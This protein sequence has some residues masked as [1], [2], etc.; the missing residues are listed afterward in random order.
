ML[1]RSIELDLNEPW[2]I[3]LFYSPYLSIYILNCLSINTR[4]FLF[5]DDTIFDYTKHSFKNDQN[6]FIQQDVL[7]SNT[8]SISN[9]VA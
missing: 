4:G 8:M 1:I 3:N 2:I 9:L 6:Y 7:K 5:L